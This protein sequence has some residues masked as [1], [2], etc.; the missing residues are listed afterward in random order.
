MSYTT[1][2]ISTLC[3]ITKD[4]S[5]LSYSLRHIT[6]EPT[7]LIFYS[8]SYHRGPHRSDFYSVSSRRGHPSLLVGDFCHT[9][10]PPLLR[11]ITEDPTALTCSLLH[12]DFYYVSYHR[13]H[14]RSHFY[15]VLYRKGP[16][17]SP[18]VV[19]VHNFNHFIV[20]T[21][22]STL[23]NFLPLSSTSSEPPELHPA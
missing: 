2:L 14:H 1:A 5:A 16:L 6:E 8:V 11:H 22:V 10:T 15:P 18:F 9:S 7:A 23:L 17:R 4:T 21:L 20:H 19:F 13:G 3:H 12:S